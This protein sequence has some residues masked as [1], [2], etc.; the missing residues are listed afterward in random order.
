MEKTMNSDETEP[1]LWSGTMSST[2]DHGYAVVIGVGYDLPDTVADAKTIAGLLSDRTRCAYLP[3]HVRLL[4]ETEACQ[5]GI[6]SALEWLGR[7]A[8]ESDTVIV[9]FS[10]H[11]AGSPEYCL[12][13]NDCRGGSSRDRAI[14]A[15]VFSHLLK[16]IQA[17]KLIVVLD[18]CYAGRQAEF[19]SP[20]GLPLSE[21]IIRE[22]GASQ[23][24]VILASSR[25][26]EVSQAGHPLSVFT[27][28]LTEGLAGYGAF[29][30]DG[31]ARILDVT[32]W[33]GRVVPDRTHDRQH[34]I[35]KVSNL[36]DNFA[37]AWYNAGDKKPR[38]LPSSGTPAQTVPSYSDSPAVVSARR[39]LDNY[40]LN[41]LLIQERM[42]EYPL[43]VD[44]PL[45]L[46][47][48]QREI[49]QKIIEIERTLGTTA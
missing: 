7:A 17:Q 43:F 4:V 48:S 23:G 12:I 42:S 30:H 35:I 9:Y 47:R 24:R 32:L 20:S 5:S 11:G 16:A 49:Q 29:E 45:L 40:R 28:A 46:V 26:D 36:K 10:G 39:M 41:L 31:Y 25:G 33:V 19:K 2:F 13:P 27:Q 3:D 14:P 18:C 34:P 22:L 44:V 1:V 38:P 8:R 6:I 21:E 37:V 15:E